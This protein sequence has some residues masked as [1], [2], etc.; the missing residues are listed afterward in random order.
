MRIGLG[1]SANSLRGIALSRGRV[2]WMQQRSREVDRSLRD[3]LK[4]LLQTAPLRRWP[5]QEVRVVFGPSVVRVKRL[6]GL[7]QS[8]EAR[9][10][11]RV[12]QAN[13]NRFF[14]H[15]EPDQLRTAVA[16][17]NDGAVFGAAIDG[18]ICED[19][20]R[21][22]DVLRLR[23]GS[24]SPAATA[25]A[26][27]MGAGSMVCVDGETV[28]RIDAATSRLV[29]IRHE[30]RH[31]DS[32]VGSTA[33]AEATQ[34]LGD[35]AAEYADA[36]AAAML[37]SPRQV[38]MSLHA[39]RWSRRARTLSRV[40][41]AAALAVSALGIV[42]PL[43]APLVGARIEIERADR[44]LKLLAPRQREALRRNSDIQYFTDALAEVSL[45]TTRGVSATAMLGDLTRALPVGVAIVTLRIDSTGA[46][47]TSLGRGAAAAVRNLE[48]LP[49][50][51]NSHIT[52]P[53][54]KEIVAG[55]ERERISVQFQIVGPRQ[56][57][58]KQP[59]FPV[60]SGS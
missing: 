45:F 50:V 13:A 7:P 22:C 57:Q 15:S 60:V 2:V 27:L 44:E 8:N 26:A 56:A 10:I 47:L 41:V 19:V 16:L 33:P 42:S 30:S 59:S 34:A 54:T 18:G 49:S 11:A 37:R 5:R 28:V 39:P 40:R 9:T 14:A 17:N 12:V 35:S 25:L 55:I 20:E 52:G 46:V 31:V 58:R 32:S 43:A 23:V 53:V 4:D 1:I 36:Y 3:S 38:Q 21:T 24:T 51:A 29:G 48:T 6:T